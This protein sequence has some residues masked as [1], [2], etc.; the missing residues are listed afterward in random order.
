MEVKGAG[1][2]KNGNTG[3]GMIKISVY[4]LSKDK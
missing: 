2:E 3:V 1:G 4:K